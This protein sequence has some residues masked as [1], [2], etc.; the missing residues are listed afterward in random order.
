M[1]KRYF[2]CHRDE[3]DD[4]LCDVLR[5]RGWIH[6]RDDPEQA[7]RK[8]RRALYVPLDDREAKTLH[9]MLDDTAAH[10]FAFPGSEAACYKTS[11]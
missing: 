9:K 8:K 3:R 5:E 10:V 11:I 2:A 7:A 4:L 6:A 1:P